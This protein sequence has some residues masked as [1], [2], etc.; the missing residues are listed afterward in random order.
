MGDD[1][2]PPITAKEADDSYAAVRRGVV[3]AGLISLGIG[4]LAAVDDI[5]GWQVYL[6]IWV[7]AYP[8]SMFFFFRWFRRQLD[9]RVRIGAMVGETPEPGTEPPNYS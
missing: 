9:E 2:Q 5:S 8:V 4:I 7:V 1:R 6:G 3:L